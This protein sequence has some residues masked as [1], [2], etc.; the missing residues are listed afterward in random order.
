MSANPAFETT[1]GTDGALVVSAEELARVGVHGGDRVRVEPVRR[2]HIRSMRGDGARPL[3]FTNEH[4]AE[5]RAEM[6][7]GLGDDLTR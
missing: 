1:V 6:G 2:R 3:G 4:L 5:L 7:E